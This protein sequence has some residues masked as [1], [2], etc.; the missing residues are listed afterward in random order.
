[1]N[2]A[3]KRKRKVEIPNASM[4]DIAFLLI[5]FFMSTTQFDI[6][7][8]VKVTLTPSESTE[9]QQSQETKL[10]EDRMTRVEI[11]NDGRVKINTEEPRDLSDEELNAIFEQKVLTREA[12]MRASTNL[13]EKKLPM[14]FILKTNIDAKYSHMVRVVDI[15]VTF[16]KQKNPD[17][18]DVQRAWLSISTEV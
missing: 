2:V 5:I 14:L 11:M 1:M 13:D 6:Q 17:N 4:S 3:R 15:L 16:T 9:E 18:S 8:G 12:A 7:E 10:T